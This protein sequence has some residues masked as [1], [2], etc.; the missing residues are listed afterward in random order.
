MRGL[1]LLVLLAIVLPYVQP[2]LSSLPGTGA[3]FA[4]GEGASTLQGDLLLTEVCPGRPVEYVIIK[5]IG[6]ATSLLNVTV[7]DGEGTV[8]IT[9]DMVLESGRSLAIT[10][11]GETLC[12]L[13]PDLR[14]LQKG[15]DG[16][17]WSG[18]FTMAD[19]GDDVRL[20][21]SGSLLDAVA[22]GTS[23][24]AGP[25][26]S[27]PPLEK[28]PKA[29]ALVRTGGDSN[30]SADWTVAP[31][32][33]SSFA[34]L[35]CSAIVEPFSVPENAAP[36]LLRELSQAVRTVNCS[37][38]EVSDPVMVSALAACAGRGVAVNVLI[39]GQ[40][41]GGLSDGC[42]N[43]SSTLLA[44]GVEVWSMR[45]NESYKRYDYVHAKYMV[46]DSR[47]VVVMSENWGNGLYA[48]R[49]WG[50]TLDG[51]EA[52]RYY[53]DVFRSDI[54]GALDVGRANEKGKVQELVPLPEAECSDILRYRCPVTAMVAPDNAAGAL[55]A[56]IARARGTILVEELSVD[57]DW[58]SGPS[59]LTALIEA[60]A[61]G[62]QVRLLL[63][64]SWG[65]GDNP[66]VAEELNKLA[67]ERGLDLEARSISSYHG[68]SVMHNK[69]LIVDDQVVVSSI[70]WGDTSLH[71]NREAGVV[72]SSEA[73]ASYF[74]SL[75]WQDWSPDPLPPQARLPWSYLTVSTGEVVLLDAS[76]CTDN[77]P[78]LEVE[79]DVDGDGQADGNETRWAVR[80]GEGNH[81]ITLTVRDRGNN[82]AT[83]V[84]WVEVVP[85]Q[86]TEPLSWT[87]MALP[88]LAAAAIAWKTIIGRKGH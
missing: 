61:R 66:E 12:A 65:G 5:N 18:R 73:I 56:L 27:G 2:G 43:A 3:S 25:G 70:N 30:T 45:S 80:L 15:D 13:Y 60:A 69:G 76:L 72:L 7:E 10:A 83:A 11:G 38:Y 46:V 67:R 55:E 77:A 52:G 26:W 28:V 81:T 21:R 58:L 84:C 31:P 49:G 47:R 8:R 42:L 33:R 9:T 39:E 48:N 20:L 59:L 68:L 41:V 22:Y 75:F 14:I 88:L 4:L 54:G 82:T 24:Y 40:P 71:Q 19:G 44:N 74:R 32:G 79:W 85:S 36:R 62:V 23:E 53:E 64:S 78:G 6:A 51:A 35:T 87:V 34:S 63:S 50:V 1:T 29:H 86:G 57:K 16:L 37:V 17:L